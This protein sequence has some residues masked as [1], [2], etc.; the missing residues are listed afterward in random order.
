MAFS[1]GPRHFQCLIT[2]SQIDILME[3]PIWLGIGLKTE[4][5]VGLFYLGEGRQALV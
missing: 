1:G 4:S 2:P 5:L 3:S